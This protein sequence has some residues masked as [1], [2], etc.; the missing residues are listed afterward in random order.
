MKRALI[1]NNVILL[2]TAFT[3]FFIVVFFALYDFD[4]R[5]QQAIMLNII[6]EVELEY[7]LF[8]GDAQAF[9]ETYQI[10]SERRITILDSNGIVIADSHDDEVGQDK[11][12]RPEI[13]S[14]GRVFIRR[15]ET[16]NVNLLYIARVMEDGNYLRVALPKD[17]HT[18][19]YN[20]VIFILIFTSLGFIAIYY[21]G[22]VKVNEHLLKPWD[23]VK[24]GLTALNER[25]FSLMS[26]NSPYPEINDILHDINDIT[27]ET[28]KHLQEIESYQLQLNEILNGL[29]QGVMLFNEKEQLVYYNEDAKVY[30]ELTEDTFMK[31]SYYAIRYNEIKDAISVAN[32]SKQASSFDLKMDGKTI[33]VKV[34]HIHAKGYEHTNATVLCLFKDVT[35][36]RA[37]EQIKRD[38]FSH[39]SHELKSPLTAI[40]GYAELIENAM[41]DPKTFSSTAKEIV[42]Q[43]ELMTMLVE[44]MLMLSRLENLK[45]KTYQ[46]ENLTAILND[47]KDGLSQIAKNKDINIQVDSEP[48]SMMCDLVDIQKLFKNVIENAIKYS[49]ANKTVYVTLK[50]QKDMILFQVKDQGYGIS[51]EHQQRVFERFYRVDKGRLDGGTGLGLAIVKHIVLKYDG[52]IDLKSSL[53]KGTTITITLKP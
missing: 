10:E 16:I 24:K 19:D 3:M 30:F 38:F 14:L 39:A 12:E 11:S 26:L 28:Q 18:E 40:R 51:P 41:V 29:K 17:D 27:Y 20:R 45:E 47:V 35:Q 48:I 4:K 52:H 34:F 2:I 22:L 25:E 21:A 8:T 23:Q 49:E 31:P 1:K 9:V 53:S 37:M 42:K 36:E 44:D 15:S 13:M 43:T 32:A 33:D 46:K 5:N 50:K 6:N 7:E